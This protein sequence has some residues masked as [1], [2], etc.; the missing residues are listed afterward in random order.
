MGRR[1]APNFSEPTDVT[2][3]LKV[4]VVRLEP[5]A[6]EPGRFSIPYPNDFTQQG[7][8]RVVFYAQDRQGINAA[9]VGPGT[10]LSIYLPAILR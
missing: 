8:Y 2:L 6:G 3:N 10:G 9:P 5:V 7:N 1:L 4:P